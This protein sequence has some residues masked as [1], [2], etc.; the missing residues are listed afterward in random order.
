TGAFRRPRE[1]NWIIGFTL[2]VLALA[3]GF[4][5]YSLPDDLL[6]GTGARI[7]YSAAISIPFIGPW[8]ASLAFGG[9]FPTTALISRFYVTH[10]LLLPAA[11]AALL[12][13]HIVLLVL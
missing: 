1:V 7:A 5:G 10:I 2:L 3:L 12:T 9:E 6:S 8:L 4:T 13:L 11:I